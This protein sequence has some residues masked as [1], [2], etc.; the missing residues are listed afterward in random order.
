M[1]NPQLHEYLDAH[2]SHVP[3]YLYTVERN[4]H[5]RTVT[6]QMLSGHMQGRFLAW[7]TGWMSPKHVLDVGTFT[8]YSSLCFAERLP[9]GGQVHTIEINEERETLIREHLALAGLEDRITLHLGDANLL[10]PKL[11]LRWDLAYLDAKKDDYPEQFELV[12]NRLA[13]GG[14]ILLDNVLWDGKVFASE[15]KKATTKLLRDFTFTL[16]QNP[17]WE[18]L[19][20]PMRDGL[21]LVREVSR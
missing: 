5:L 13:P 20:L 19:M 3:D 16:A 12:A 7:L 11:Q 9:A 18:T 2:A 6:P 17:R 15:P 1:R 10:I 14:H 4:T 8:G 21:M